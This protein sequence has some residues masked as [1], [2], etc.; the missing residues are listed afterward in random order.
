VPTQLKIEEVHDALLELVKEIIGGD[1]YADGISNEDLEEDGS[2]A[3]IQ[4]PAILL[5]F[6]TERVKP[7]KDNYRLTYQSV[8]TYSLLVGDSSLRGS[9]DERTGALKLV[10]RLRDGL[11]GEKLTVSDG[12]TE[13]I[14]LSGSSRYQLAKTGTWYRVEINVGTVVQFSAKS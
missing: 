4:L 6:D 2:I 14:E 7:Q 5:L 11:A 9:D 13:P 3:A 12:I 8:Q 1:A 10:S